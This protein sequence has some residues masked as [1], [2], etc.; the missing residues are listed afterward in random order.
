MKTSIEKEETHERVEHSSRLINF[1]VLGGL[2]FDKTVAIAYRE[3]SLT[4]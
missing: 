2:F 1:M 3:S 4:I